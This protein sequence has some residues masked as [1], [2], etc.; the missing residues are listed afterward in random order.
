MP[1]CDCYT[2]W[3]TSFPPGCSRSLAFW[4]LP[5][6]FGLKQLKGLF[7]TWWFDSRVSWTEARNADD[8]QGH[9][10]SEPSP[11][12]SGSEHQSTAEARL[13]N[14]LPGNPQSH[15]N[16]D[17][18]HSREWSHPWNSTVFPKSA[19]VIYVP[20]GPSPGNPCTTHSVFPSSP[21]MLWQLQ[22]TLGSRKLTYPQLGIP[23]GVGL[24]WLQHPW[25]AGPPP[26]L[27]ISLPGNQKYC[28][29]DSWTTWDS[30]SFGFA[31]SQVSILPRQISATCPETKSWG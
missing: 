13:R 27:H 15:C 17:T 25:H 9:C 2:Q 19:A 31:Y 22:K 5:G 29:S 21:P 14:Y 4:Q 6:G 30:S 8:S 16:S 28:W 26:H 11:A 10:D 20:P 12:F 3:H 1:R 7:E 24:S 18:H 23:K